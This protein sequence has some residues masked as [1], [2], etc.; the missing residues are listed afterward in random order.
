ML[1][2][3]AVPHNYY[4]REMYLPQL[5]S[6]PSGAAWM[7]DGDEL[8]YSMQGSLWRQRIGETEAIQ[9]VD[10]PGYAYQPDVSRD[11]AWIVYTVYVDDALELRALETA[12]GR[13]ERLLADG[14][15]NLEPR[16]SPDG[17]RI[18]FVSTSYEGRWHVFVGDF[19]DGALRN[20]TRITEDNDSKL[21]RYYYSV[22]DHYLSPSWS[23]DGSE[24]LL[25]SNR[26]KIW[27]TG[28]FWR[29][30]AKGGALRPVHDEETTWKA[31]PDWSPDGRRIVYASYLGRQWHQLWLTT[32]APGGDAFQLTY[33]DFDAVAPRWSPDGSR[34]AFVSNEGGGL[35]LKVLAMPG[36]AVTELVVQRRRWLAPRRL[37]S[38]RVTGPDGRSMPARVSVTGADGRGYAPADAWIHADDAFDRRERSFELSYFH[39]PGRADLQ[40]PGGRYV[41]EVTRG[42]EYRRVVDTVTI[43]QQSVVHRVRLDRLASLPGWWSGDLHVHMNYGGAYRNTPARLLAQAEAEDL[44]VVENLIVNKESR[45]PDIAYFD[46]RLDPVS[47]SAVLIKHDEEH[48]TSYWGHTGLLGLTQYFVMPNYAGYVNTAAQSL[49]PHNTAIADLARAQGGVQGYV[50]PFDGLPDPAAPDALTHALPVDVA[51]GRTGYL[52]VVGF[53]DHRA[54]ASVWYRLLNL[55]FRVPAGAGTDA[56]ANFASLRGPVGLNRVFV[57][58]PRL[59]YR[60]WLDGLARG[61]T[62]ATNGPLLGLELGGLGPGDTLSLGE[63]HQLEARIS[64]RSIVAVDSL[65]LVRNGV[66]V[67]SIPIDSAGTFAEARLAVAADRSGW[68]VLRAFATGSRH[69]TLD[70]YPY[71]TT[72]PI[73]VSL[74]GQP[75]RSAT[76]ASYF[77]AWIERLE[78]SASG[79]AGWATDAER[80]LVL[81]DLARAKAIFVERGR[82]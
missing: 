1:K 31:R 7:P 54:T 80:E 82:E 47:T 50:H 43:G 76:D 73:Y 46:R 63:P 14:A 55:G 78:R 52:E 29:L 51:L 8:V 15:V 59:E 81:A 37:L 24:L 72:S 10:G 62:F 74:R 75:L 53:S 42:L 5:T 39:A 66:V 56:M 65:E 28:G 25:I 45:I 69:P 44:H 27:G 67:A 30:P 58:T 4:Y 71:A 34:I 22:H 9:L 33:G 17:R 35:A 61:R 64:L 12:T 13:T 77:V 23:P 49:Y 36:G 26:G 38:I 40:V 2:Q 19:A 16:F 41:V 68:Y 3:I 48:H 79:H 57:R 32:A 18:A 11:G 20:V 6:G 21:P 70:V 60:A